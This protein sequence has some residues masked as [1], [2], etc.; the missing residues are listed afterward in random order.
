MKS[1]FSFRSEFLT[2]WHRSTTTAIHHQSSTLLQEET[3]QSIARWLQ[4]MEAT[5]KPMPY[6]FPGTGKWF[7][8]HSD[9]QSWLLNSPSILWCHGPPGVGKSYLASTAIQ[10]LAANAK[11]QSPRSCITHFFC[12]VAAR[13][14]QH[15]AA[16]LS[17]ILSQAAEQG[18]ASVI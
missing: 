12:D 16:I 18:N 5:S 9:Y 14:E 1:D 8:T 6:S 13:K 15:T 2:V 11:L 7:T 3:R 17:N 4:K 10:D